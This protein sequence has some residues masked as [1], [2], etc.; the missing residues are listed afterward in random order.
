MRK[1]A[2]VAEDGHGKRGEDI[3]SCRRVLTGSDMCVMRSD[4]RGDLLHGPY[5]QR[6][7]RT[8]QFGDLSRSRLSICG[9]AI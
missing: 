3:G 8:S 2:N 6:E 5:G 7:F 1:G 4:E 9:K